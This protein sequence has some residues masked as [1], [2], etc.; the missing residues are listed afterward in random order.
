MVRPAHPLSMAI[1][2][3]PLL[4]IQVSGNQPLEELL[5]TAHKR[6]QNLRDVPAPLSLL[7]GEK[8]DSAHITTTEKLSDY[9]PSLS[10]TQTGIGSSIAIRGISSGVNQGFEQSVGLFVDGI[11]FG[12]AQLSRAPLLDI[13]RVEVLRGPQSILFG[14]NTTAGAISITTAKPGEDAQSNLSLLYEPEHGERDIRVVVSSPISEQFGLR[15]ALLD[16]VMD[17]YMTNTTLGRK[18]P[19][20]ENRVVRATVS[21]QDDHWLGL[22]KLESGSFDSSGRNIEV[23]KPVFNTQVPPGP[24]NQ[25]PPAIAYSDVLQQLQPG[26]ILDTRQDFSR[27][28][29]GDT[30]LNST[31]NITLNLERY[32]GEHHFTAISAY[33]SYHYDEHCDC[34]FVGTPGFTIDSREKYRQVSQELR[35]SSAPDRPLNYIGGLFWQSSRLHFHDAINLDNNSL[36]AT[37]LRPQLGDAA[38]LLYGASTQR[39]FAQDTD[40]A[41]IFLQATWQMNEQLR[42]L[43]GGRYTHESKTAKRHLYHVTPAG[44]PLPQGSANDSYNRV[45]SVFRVEPHQIDGERSESAFTPAFTLQYDTRAS[46]MLYLSYST[47]FKSGGFDVR[48]NA[49]PRYAGGIYPHLEGTWEFADEK[50]RNIEVGGKFLFGDGRAELNL[51]AFRSQFTDMQTS[52]FDGAL[53]FNVTNA[54]EARVQGI[55]ADSR[56]A[57]SDPLLLRAN[58]AYLDF[59]YVRFPN[60]SCYFGQADNQPPFGDGLCDASGKRREFT[61]KWKGNLGLDHQL[62]LGNHLTLGS[63][64]DIIYSSAYLTS[65]SLDPNIAQPAYYKINARIALSDSQN[66]WELALVGKNLNDEAIVTYANGLPISTLL[67]RNTSTAY[68]AMYER[69]RSIA[70]QANLRF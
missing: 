5:V 1:A 4:S 25:P 38:K 50:A 65:P 3:I 37:A 46:N 15:I 6:E 30:S 20:S 44:T 32:L 70:L 28:A 2:L 60:A 8:I 18:E 7:S 40:I 10:I 69:P 23:I 31:Q 12:R 21:W 66:Q 62:A 53:T 61:P 57:I 22:L 54:G 47:G 11:H 34:D 59:N 67:T 27:Q 35:L 42:A 55:E 43:I 68:Y 29:N 16:S 14:K 39:D 17:G 56:W 64:L 52:Q 63:S 9:I 33:N 48:A 26:Y 58:V 49:A 13:E 19:S 51:A 45:W 36:I 24:N 41:A